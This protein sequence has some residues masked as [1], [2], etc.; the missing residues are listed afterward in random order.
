MPGS[1]P[2]M[3]YSGPVGVVTT[4]DVAGPLEL[5]AARRSSF[6]RR[7]TQFFMMSI[8]TGSAMVVPVALSPIV[9]F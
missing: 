6:R 9:F 8:Q 5:R 7:S 3:K 1:V 2:T 4:I